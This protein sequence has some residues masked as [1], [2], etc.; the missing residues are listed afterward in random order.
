MARAGLANARNDSSPSGSCSVMPMTRAFTATIDRT[1]RRTHGRSAAP[2]P[3]SPQADSTSADVTRLPS[4]NRASLSRVRTHV[5]P[6]GSKR[7]VDASP[8]P[9]RPSQSTRTNVSYTCRNSKRSLS[10]LGYGACV[11]S[12]GPFSATVRI[13]APRSGTRLQAGTTGAAAAGGTISTAG[14][15]GSGAA[16]TGG[17]GG[18]STTGDG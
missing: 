10:F 2:R 14:A 6:V 13:G 15:G 11:A 8:R 4:E 12:M 7:Q 5:G 1:N 16:T 17:G 18:G 9:T 3:G